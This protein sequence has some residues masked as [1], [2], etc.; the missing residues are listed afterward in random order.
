MIL[1][2][3]KK[4]KSDATVQVKQMH[5]GISKDLQHLHLLQYTNTFVH[6]F[7]GLNSALYSS[8]NIQTSEPN[9][10]CK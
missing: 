3:Y 10:K 4:D 1:L 7:S 6:H 8:V 9:D 5:S 2:R